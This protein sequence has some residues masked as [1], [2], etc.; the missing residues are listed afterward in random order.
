[1]GDPFVC[2]C[3]CEMFTKY[4]LHTLNARCLVINYVKS[5]III[6]LSQFDQALQLWHLYLVKGQFI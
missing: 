1:M 3:A 5:T 4:Q 2:V 6:L